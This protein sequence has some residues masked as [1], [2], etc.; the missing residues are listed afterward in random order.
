MCGCL[1]HFPCW[2]PRLRRRHV[3]LLGIKP[4][5]LWFTGWCSIHWATPARVVTYFLIKKKYIDIFCGSNSTVVF[6]IQMW[7][8]L[9]QLFGEAESSSFSWL[10]CDR[11]WIQWGKKCGIGQGS[12]VASSLTLTTPVGS[13]A[14]GAAS[15]V[16]DP[17][18]TA[19]GHERRPA[20]KKPSCGMKHLL[21]K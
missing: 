6:K 17:T 11:F 4:V 18:V 16:P 13:L 19:F 8:A 15:S 3:P 1:S 2:R 7:F 10:S 9:P 14:N 21:A 12:K 5:T 20:Q